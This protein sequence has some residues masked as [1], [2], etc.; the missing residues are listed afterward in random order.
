MLIRFEIY[1]E[2]LEGIDLVQSTGPQKIRRQ[3]FI[4]PAADLLPFEDVDTSKGLI[5]H[6]NTI[7]YAYNPNRTC[8]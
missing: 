5:N 2:K 3:N 6:I 7:S 1:Q 8:P 4:H